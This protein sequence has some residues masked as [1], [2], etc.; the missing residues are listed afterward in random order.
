MGL[1]DVPV[2]AVERLASND[3]KDI[4]KGGGGEASYILN[5]P[6]CYYLI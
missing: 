5:L 4:L 6:Q 3:D 2:H 1:D